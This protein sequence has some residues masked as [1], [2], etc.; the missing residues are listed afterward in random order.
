[1]LAAP[2]TVGAQK[3]PK[4]ARVG[5]L[6]AG[7]TPNRDDLAKS[8]ATNAR[9]L[10]QAPLN[11]HGSTSTPSSSEARGWASCCNQDQDLM[12]LFKA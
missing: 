8:V 11:L 5:I 4:V 6:G 10:V 1:M 12:L 2:I 3:A 7:P 9:W